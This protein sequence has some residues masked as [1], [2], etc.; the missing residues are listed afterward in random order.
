MLNIIWIYE[1]AS[2][3]SQN[4][5]GDDTSKLYLCV[6]YVS[7]KHVQLNHFLMNYPVFLYEF[8]FSLSLFILTMVINNKE[9]K[10]S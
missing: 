6:R 8:N 10:F 1:I 2:G 4:L 7:P 5:T 9:D 3:I